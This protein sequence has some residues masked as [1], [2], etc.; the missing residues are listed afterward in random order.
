MTHRTKL[1]RI[2]TA[3]AV[4]LALLLTSCATSD[5]GSDDGVIDYWLWDSSQ[6]PGYQECAKAF[7]AQNPELHINFSQYGWDDYWSKLT[8]GLIADQ[9][10]DVFTNHLAKYPQLVDLDVLLE[11]DELETTKD[12]D[13]ADF[14]SGLAELWKG[15]DGHRYGVPKDWDTIAYFYDS[16]VTDEAG[17]TAEQLNTMDWNPDDGGSFE[18]I[19]AHLTVDS[20]GVRGDEPG[21]DKDHVKV[22]GLATGGAG[23]DNY[24]QAQWGAYVDSLKDWQIL[25]KNPWGTHFN[26]DDPEFQKTIGWYFGL[27]EKGFMPRYDTFNKETGSYQQMASGSAVLGMNGSWMVSTFAALP[28]IQLEIAPTPIGPSGHRASPFNGLADSVTKFASNPENAGKWVDFMASDECQIIIGEAGVVFP[29]KES[30]TKASLEVRKAAGID[31]SAFTVHID[32]GTTTLQA[33]TA[34]AADFDALT[35]PAFEAIYIGQAPV[36]SLTDLND[37]MNRFFELVSD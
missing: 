37:Q 35:R 29:A 26:F 3:S 32:E 12:I 14:Q 30:G 21:F 13:D 22:F 27:A 10:P 23:G 2:A 25:D 34:N 5:E 17:I 9:A 31:T 8:A 1:S 7:E 24:G 33:V 20:N 36:S 19:I 11:L 18:Q 6:Q 28:D 16:R 4:G 15:Q